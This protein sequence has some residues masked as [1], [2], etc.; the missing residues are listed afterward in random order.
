MLYI[1]SPV[2]L[3]EIAA[4]KVAIS[5]CL[6][7]PDVLLIDDEKIKNVVKT[8]PIDA[9]LQQ[10]IEGYVWKV[11]AELVGW[12]EYHSKLFFLF[13]RRIGILRCK[14]EFTLNEDDISMVLLK[15]LGKEIVWKDDG[16]L[17]YLRTARRLL[18]VPQLSDEDKYSIMCA[19]CMEE[20]L[21][22]AFIMKRHSAI[23][24]DDWRHPLI[25]YWN[26]RLNVHKSSVIPPYDMIRLNLVDNEYAMEYFLNGLEK[27]QL[28]SAATSIARHCILSN[29]LSTS[30]V[31]VLSKMNESQ[32]QSFLT[33]D[34]HLAVRALTSSLHSPRDV[35][36]GWCCIKNSLT[37]MSFVHLVAGCADS[38]VIFDAI[39]KDAS[40]DLKSFALTCCSKVFEECRAIR[41]GRRA[42]VDKVQSLARFLCYLD[43]A[44]RMKV[45][46]SL[47]F[48]RFCL[49]LLVFEKANLI[50]Q[51]IDVC[52][53]QP[54]QMVDFKMDLMNFNDARVYC[55][56]QCCELDV[57]K[58]K[59]ISNDFLSH[60]EII[61]TYLINLLLTEEGFNV[62]LNTLKSA[63][64]SAFYRFYS[65]FLAKDSYSLLK[66]RIHTAIDVWEMCL[67]HVSDL[68]F[69]RL[70]EFFDFYGVKESYI[71]HFVRTVRVRKVTEGRK[72]I[73]SFIMEILKTKIG[74]SWC[75]NLLRLHMSFILSD[76]IRFML[77]K[78][79][80][81]SEKEIKLEIIRSFNAKCFIIQM[82]RFDKLD[83]SKWSFDVEPIFNFFFSLQPGSLKMTYSID[84][85]PY[86]PFTTDTSDIIDYF[87]RLLSGD[88]I[89]KTFPLK[90]L[91]ITLN[92][93]LN[94]MFKL[95]IQRAATKKEIIMKLF[96]HSLLVHR[97]WKDIV[98][99]ID[100]FL[101][102][103]CDLNEIQNQ[104]LL[105]LLR[106]AFVDYFLI[107]GGDTMNDILTWTIDSKEISDIKENAF[108]PHINIFVK[109]L[110][111]SI[112]ML[113][114]RNELIFP[115]CG[116]NN[117]FCELDKF[118]S[119]YFENPKSIRM[120]KLERIS[121]W[122]EIHVIKT[123]VM[124]K[125]R[126]CLEIV[127]KWFFDGNE[128]QIAKFKRDNIE[129]ATVF[130]SVLP[131]F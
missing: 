68:T 92:V 18:N 17:D 9:S 108:I 46:N 42:G 131:K 36:R 76:T 81:V 28:I 41:C 95:P 107:L 54:D 57:K 29:K 104:F 121:K 10:P 60:P 8:L 85:S 112:F 56:Q 66:S 39:W 3:K 47:Q 83:W 34:R 130:E 21:K 43:P 7:F 79:G 73:A 88:H 52:H 5:L 32:L 89:P 11:H 93:I 77:P 125:R 101:F 13:E 116:K 22:E 98:C 127:L 64:P 67:N 82:L 109:M 119:W 12:I 71:E 102:V 80:V 106:D 27:D 55:L 62:C 40:K 75:V 63:G 24:V 105:H 122:K 65:Q 35:L 50:N 128:E 15:E 99:C 25:L 84:V 51:L 111:L 74:F 113:K 110:E 45:I 44:T 94:N 49:E 118:L 61:D 86:S 19:Y 91:V 53:L 38:T 90:Q 2:S 16:K 96:K 100:G 117:E 70:D 87:T 31:L 103:E 69:E 6:R 58:M 30:F 78:L 120:F 115:L 26:K 1:H 37:G 23:E 59:I 114:R 129:I 4:N 72:N 33:V 124:E 48:M 126:W 14:N 123:L 97:C 20:E